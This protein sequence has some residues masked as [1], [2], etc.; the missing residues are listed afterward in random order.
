MLDIRLEEYN[1]KLENNDKFIHTNTFSY[2]FYRIYIDT[3][4]INVSSPIIVR[5]KLN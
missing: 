3:P 2:L 4:T 1:T 5:E